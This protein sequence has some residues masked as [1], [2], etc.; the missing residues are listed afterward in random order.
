MDPPLRPSNRKIPWRSAAALSLCLSIFMPQA[1]SGQQ[2]RAEVTVHLEALPTLQREQMAEF[3]YVLT[4]YV[5]E[6]DWMEEDLPDPVEVGFE[7][8]LAFLGSRVKTQ[9]GSRLTVYSGTDLKYL[10]R[11]WLF[12]FEREDLL[13]HDD[14]QFHPVTWLV[15]Y[16]VHIMIGHEL[17]K[18]TEFGGDSHFQRANAIALDGRFSREFQRG[19][20]E[21]LERID[22]IQAEEYRPH[23]LIRN[24][25]Y[26][27]MAAQRENKLAEARTLCREAVD[28]MAELYEKNPR[29]ERLQDF[30]NAH[31]L[32]LADV[33]IAESSTE[34][35]DPESS[36]EAYDILMEIDS[37]HRSTYEE[38]TNRLGG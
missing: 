13:Q 30:L 36:R 6:W 15:D 19:W 26:R 37:A 10:D 9:Y 29:D 7:V 24:R 34:A 33:F 5:E 12:E 31:Y 2:V 22:A 16:Y 20:D 25:Y 38:Y 32:Q 27:G 21:R 35:P 8:I 4:S 11:W 23:R 28:I 1:A 18:F 17:D 3:D 14:R